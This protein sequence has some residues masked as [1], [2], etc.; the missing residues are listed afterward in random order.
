MTKKY[1]NGFKEEAVQRVNALKKPL[2]MV[3][4]ELR[5]LDTTIHQ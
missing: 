1:N 4:K 5:I 2:V 3:A